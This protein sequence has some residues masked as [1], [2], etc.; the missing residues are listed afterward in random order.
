LLYYDKYDYV[1]SHTAENK[2]NIDFS[3]LIFPIFP[4]SLL[5]RKKKKRE[6]Y[7]LKK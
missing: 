1:Y 3:F 2:E 6:F 7:L 5:S 4:A